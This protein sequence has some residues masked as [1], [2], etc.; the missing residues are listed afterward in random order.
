MFQVIQVKL[1]SSENIWFDFSCFIIMILFKH[2]I[3]FIFLPA[4]WLPTSL[5]PALWL[6]KCLYL[7]LQF[8]LHTFY[9]MSHHNHDCYDVILVVKLLIKLLFWSNCYFNVIMLIFC[10]VNLIQCSFCYAHDALMQKVL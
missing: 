1:Y 10:N 2:L 5:L 6:L 4:L 9:W 8:R 3:W 7:Q